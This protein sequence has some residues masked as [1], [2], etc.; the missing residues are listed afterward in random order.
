MLKDTDTALSNQKA[1]KEL[2]EAVRKGI[3]SGGATP[4][5]MN[6]IIAEARRH[7]NQE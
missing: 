7:K 5:D 3:E 1:I 4:L 2:R 6:E